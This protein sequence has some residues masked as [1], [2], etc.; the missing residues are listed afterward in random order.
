MLIKNKDKWIFFRNMFSVKFHTYIHK[1][2]MH[3]GT[4]WNITHSAKHE[5]PY[6]YVAGHK[7]KSVIWHQVIM[8]G[9]EK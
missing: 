2:T 4:K 1:N 6:A 9:T 5:V 3:L 7:G 8:N